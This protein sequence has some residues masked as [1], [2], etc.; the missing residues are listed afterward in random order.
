MEKLSV[1]I[2]T[3]NEEKKVS[4]AIASVS[5]ADEI[6][7]V[8]SFST[9]RTVEIARAM[10]ARVE[11]LDFPGF[12]ELRNRAMAL[13]SN[14]WIFSLDAD[15]RCSPQVEAEIRELLA[16]TP[17]HDAYFV[18]RRNFFMGRWLK[19]SAF[20]PDYRQP[21]LFRKGALV[22]SPER[23][24]ESYR[25]ASTLPPGYMVNPIWQMPFVDLAELMRKADRYSTLGAEKLVAE[26]RV[27]GMA[28]AF[29]RGIWSFLHMFVLKKGFRDG[30]AGFAIAVGNFNGT[31]FKY[32]KLYEMR[33]AAQGGESGRSSTPGG[34]GGTVSPPSR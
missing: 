19:S 18:P 34:S 32:A 21:Q 3:K 27:C 14:P 33:Q 11:E 28:T 20:F 23:V 26:G 16:G 25:I 2:L 8:D 5:W 12:G 31:F 6:L 10:G 15:E 22:F 17:R 9:D 30:W 1:Y 4:A 29:F 24:H 13:C 7:V